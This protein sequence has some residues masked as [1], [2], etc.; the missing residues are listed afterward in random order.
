MGR[1]NK[2]PKYRGISSRLWAD[3]KFRTM[4]APLPNAQSLWF[5]LLTGPMLTSLPGIFRGGEAALAEELEWPLAEFRAAFA[6]LEDR[7]MAIADWKHRLVWLPNGLRHNPPANPNIVSGWRES[8]ADLPEC[9]L[10]ITA[11][12]AFAEFMDK[13]GRNYKKKFAEFAGNS[14]DR[15]GSYPAHLEDDD[16]K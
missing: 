9:E 11:R 4:S 6:E 3:E 15:E 7:G 10:K 8:W 5:F 14:I 16:A 1:P 13:L 12:T 2:G